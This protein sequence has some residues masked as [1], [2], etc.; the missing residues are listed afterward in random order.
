VPKD[1]QYTVTLDD[2]GLK[3]APLEAEAAVVWTLVPGDAEALQD[4]KL[5]LN[6]AFMQGRAKAAGD[7]R[8]LLAFLK[9]LPR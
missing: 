3:V 8:T 6:V 4:G 7:G 5:D 1:A 9:S 2:G